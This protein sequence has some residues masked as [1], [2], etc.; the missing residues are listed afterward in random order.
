[1]Y[2]LGQ[3]PVTDEDFTPEETYAIYPELKQ[4]KAS[5]IDYIESNYITK[6]R[7]AAEMSVL[8][9]EIMLLKAKLKERNS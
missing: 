7:H 3:D 9:Q 1:M 5:L 4:A 6:V 2:N 8:D